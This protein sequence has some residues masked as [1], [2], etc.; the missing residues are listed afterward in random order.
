PYGQFPAD[1]ASALDNT[2]ED[3]RV[4]DDTIDYTARDSAWRHQKPDITEPI[5]AIYYPF[6]PTQLI[7]GGLLWP[8][9]DTSNNTPLPGDT[10]L[11]KGPSPTMPPNNGTPDYDLSTIFNWPFEADDSIFMSPNTSESCT[12][13]WTF[14]S[15]SLGEQPPP[16]SPSD[17]TSSLYNS[18]PP[19]F[20]SPP[21]LATF[22]LPPPLPP[23]PPLL[24]PPPQS[25]PGV[26]LTKS[27]SD[28]RVASLKSQR[29]HRGVGR[30]LVELKCPFCGK[31]HRRPHALQ[32]SP[33]A[34]S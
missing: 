15:T 33:Q 22:P 29:R 1:P 34:E 23:P 13:D 10:N 4:T 8:I 18:D 24:P 7:D 9:L 17:S 30:S 12:T 16:F 32:C 21:R 31:I 5:T 11:L 20:P 26:I 14:E 27:E 28:A 2:Q 19:D 3:V 25:S 6:D